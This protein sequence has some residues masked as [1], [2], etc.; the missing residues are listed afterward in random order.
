MTSAIAIIAPGEMGCA[1][2]RSFAGSPFRVLTNLAGRSTRSAERAREAGIEAVE[3]DAALVAQSRF[4]LSVV[5]P[6][7][8]VAV[9][10]RFAPAIAAS[11]SKPVYIDCNAIAPETA[12]HIADVL[13]PS[14]ADVLDGVLFGGPTSLKPGLIIHVSGTGAERARELAGPQLTVHTIDGPVG[15]ASALK[16]CFAG[17]NKGYIALGAAMMRAAIAA[18]CEENLVAQLRVS[19]QPVL[20]YMARAVPPML[21]KAH[22]WDGEMH[23]IAAFLG[24]ETAMSAV[25]EALSD[26]YA[27]LG[28]DVAKGGDAGLDALV[29]TLTG[30]R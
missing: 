4:L 21:P 24:P 18:G 3:D 9:A 5:P 28:R 29:R 27:A 15:A 10:E 6:A 11:A 14:G 13:A 19:H 26:F 17:I 12:R 30:L 25:F 1:I 7:E 23:E 16:L 22:R 8:A 20:D 2:A